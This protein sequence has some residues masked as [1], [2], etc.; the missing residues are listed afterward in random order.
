MSANP[1]VPARNARLARLPYP[2]VCA[3]LGIALSWVPAFLHGPIPQKFNVLYID[4]AYAVWAYYSSRAL[5]GF[6]VGVAVWPSRWYVRGP[7]LGLLGMLPVT[8]IALGMPGCG[9][10]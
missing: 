10:T 7:A 8:F 9:F 2:L 6:W 5:I 4:G 3:A 1:P